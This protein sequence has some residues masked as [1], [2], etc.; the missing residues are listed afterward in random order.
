MFS[1]S[2]SKIVDKNAMLSR[3]ESIQR[4][5]AINL[6]KKF[7]PLSKAIFRDK[8][9]ELYPNLLQVSNEPSLANLIANERDTALNTDGLQ[10][11]S[12]AKNNLLTIADVNTTDYILDRLSDE[13]IQTLNQ[14]FPKFVKILTT[15]YKNIDK[16][17]FI[18][19]I[20]SDTFDI[21]DYEVTERGQSRINR[22]SDAEVRK[23][24]VE[25]RDEQLRGERGAPNQ[26][27]REQF[28]EYPYELQQVT[29]KK[30]PNKGKK[31]LTPKSLKTQYGQILSQNDPDPNSE[32]ENQ[33]LLAAE[34]YSN[35]F[36][37]KRGLSSYIDS[38]ISG[39]VPQKYNKTQLQ[40]IA[41]K[42]RYKELLEDSVEGN[43]VKRR[44]MY[45]RGMPLLPRNPSKKTLNDGKFTLDLDKLKRNILSVT[46]SSCRAVIPSLKKEHVSN[47]VKNMIL[48][49]VEG[50]YNA[51]LFN[52]MKQDDQRV[53]SNFVRVLK[54]PDIDMSEFD[55]GYQLHYEVLLG[56]VNSGQNN[57]AIKRELKEYILRAITE[58]LIPK[59][60]GL[61]K[62]FELSL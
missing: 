23:S 28:E 17:K 40:E 14:S 20:K 10:S 29:P 46:Y 37:D 57:P 1:I 24:I 19:L 38:I 48:D 43:G 47:D 39:N 26:I 22:K 2:G 53:V 9:M 34:K 56:Q 59:S 35:S 11:Y 25:K 49:I 54:I 58:N 55:A 5:I 51:N 44:K 50:K 4:Q 42:L 16:N 13:N 15:K 31:E 30:N 8:Q 41:L 18:E 33:A 52:K 61:T 12:I 7:D 21:P 36:K 62:L 32:R 6:Q 60:Q 3:D 27:D 45:G